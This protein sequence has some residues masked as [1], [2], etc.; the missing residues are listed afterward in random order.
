LADLKKLL[1]LSAPFWHQNT[2]AL[3]LKGAQVKEELADL[4]PEWSCHCFPSQTDPSG[5][6]VEIRKEN[7]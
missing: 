3:F 1:A 5:V 2:C 6:I 4:S 7:A